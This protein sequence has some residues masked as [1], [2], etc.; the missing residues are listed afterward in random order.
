MAAPSLSAAQAKRFSYV[1][2]LFKKKS[3]TSTAAVRFCTILA[4]TVET[5]HINN[6]P[7]CCFLRPRGHHSMVVFDAIRSE[8][9]GRANIPAVAVLHPPN[10]ESD[11]LITLPLLPLDEPGPQEAD[12][13]KGESKHKESNGDGGDRECGKT[14][15]NSAPKSGLPNTKEQGAR[16]HQH[17]HH[18][19]AAGG[20][21]SRM[22]DNVHKHIAKSEA[23]TGTLT[24][25]LELFEDDEGKETLA[26]ARSSAGVREP[27]APREPA[28]YAA[29][30]IKVAEDAAAARRRREKEGIEVP[31]MLSRVQV[32]HDR[33]A[34]DANIR[35]STVGIVH[36]TS[37]TQR[38]CFV[39]S[40][41]K[42]R[43]KMVL[44]WYSYA[45]KPA[46]LNDREKSCDC[47]QRDTPPP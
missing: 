31:R 44:L 46:T 47:T 1:V 6:I 9:L 32:L 12:T 35:T 20:F 15:E 4:L 36:L 39:S 17:K 28:E 43:R 25:S 18:G 7:K 2:H 34:G 30:K 3:N 42:L 10:G 23:I 29:A 24:V 11:G 8:F 26:G 19:G 45:A 21:A 5:T 16:V 14:N 33:L 27:R 37:T 22:I 40:T 13:A 41:S 38:L